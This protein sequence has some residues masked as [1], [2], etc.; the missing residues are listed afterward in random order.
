MCVLCTEVYLQMC[1]MVNRFNYMP[2]YAN[3]RLDS[4]MHIC[5]YSTVTMSNIATFKYLTK[6]LLWLCYGSDLEEDKWPY[7]STEQQKSNKAS[8]VHQQ[9]E[10]INLFYLIL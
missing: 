9:R 3:K 5:L 1:V 8:S 7:R 10:T 2:S 6:V 4:I